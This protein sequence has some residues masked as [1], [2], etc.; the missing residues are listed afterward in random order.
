M[1]FGFRVWGFLDGG[2]DLIMYRSE[3]LGSRA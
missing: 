2:L 1:G 3:D